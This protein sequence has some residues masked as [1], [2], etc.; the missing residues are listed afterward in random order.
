MD[1]TIVFIVITIIIGFIGSLFMNK[2]NPWM[3]IVIS[4][5]LAI[6]FVVLYFDKRESTSILMIFLAASW[7]VKIINSM[8]DNKKQKKVIS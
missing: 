3:Q 6:Y 2:A 8:N 4:G 5:S 1:N 7:I